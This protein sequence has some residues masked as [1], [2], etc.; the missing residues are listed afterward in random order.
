[1]SAVPLPDSADELVATLV[2]RRIEKT[3]GDAAGAERLL[4]NLV[5]SIHVEA[6]TLPE[7]LWRAKFCRPADSR[8]AARRLIRDE[9][10]RPEYVDLDALAARY[11]DAESA[12]GAE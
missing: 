6:G 3:G 5:G 11:D 4:R 10:T 7:A 2:A 12:G 9:A 1:M 8:E